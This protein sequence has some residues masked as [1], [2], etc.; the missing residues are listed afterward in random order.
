MR[1]PLGARDLVHLRPRDGAGL[2]FCGVCVALTGVSVFL[3]SRDSVTAWLA[4]QVL[5]GVA[6]VQWFALLHESG[7]DTLF[8]TRWLHKVVGH[9]AGFFVGIP[10]ESWKRVHA[11]HHKWTGWQDI[12][13]TTVALVPRPLGR[14]ERVLVDVCW[15]TWIPLFSVLYRLGNFWAVTRL[16]RLFPR[17]TVR[18]RLVTNVA[19]QLAVYAAVASLVGLG[20]VVRLVGLGVL[21]SLVFEDPLLLSQHTH[22]PLNQSGGR[23]VA[24][25]PAVDQAVFTRSLSFP[26]WVSA[27]VLLNLGAHEL[28]HMYP[29]V[30]GYDLGRIACPT[31]ND[32]PWWQWVRAAKGVPGR[33]LLFQNR[34]Q[35]GLD[36]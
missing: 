14:G 2:A 22:I 15:K 11:L 30:P 13:P 7:H 23:P 4:G 5:L 36:I 16:W 24:P 6:L 12:D 17:P 10:F 8:R 26:R 25:Y 21:L 20:T 3:A 31:G 27:G 32:V 9:V 34:T 33:I 1:W 35:S 28:H 19:C 18:R 29:F